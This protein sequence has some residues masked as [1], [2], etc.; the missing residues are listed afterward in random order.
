MSENYL[1][2]AIIGKY[3]SLLKFA[4][5]LG[6][7]SRKVYDIVNGNQEPSGRDIEVI[8]NAL[9]VDIPDEIRKLFFA[10]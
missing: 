7:S 6:W 8:C 2:G 3:G 4:E 10:R 5:V 1:R 9:Q